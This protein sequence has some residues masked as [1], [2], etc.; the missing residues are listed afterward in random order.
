M[1]SLPPADAAIAAEL[2]GEEDDVEVF[3]RFQIAEKLGE[4]T[5][6]KVYKAVSRESGEFFALKKIRILYEE[7]GVPGTAI[8]EVSLLKECDHPNVI[9]LHE[10]FSRPTALYLV[11]EFLDMD[12]RQYIKKHGPFTVPHR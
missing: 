2:R 11:F 7:E 1:S 8:R 3:G 9:K 4:G 5:Y 12:L 10:V 6:G